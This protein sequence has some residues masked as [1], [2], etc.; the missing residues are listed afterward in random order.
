MSCVGSAKL[1]ESSI[2]Q[3]DTNL[4]GEPVLI[5]GLAALSFWQNWHVAFTD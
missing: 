2:G 4:K 3:T 5:I 1:R